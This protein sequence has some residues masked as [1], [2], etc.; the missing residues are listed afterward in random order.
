MSVGTARP[1]EADFTKTL[2]VILLA[3]YLGVTAARGLS[4]AWT[5]AGPIAGYAALGL[6]LSVLASNLATMLI[7]F[8]MRRDRAE[9]RFAMISLTMTAG[10]V[11][12]LVAS[13]LSTRPL[14]H[15][16]ACGITA[17]AMSAT[18]ALSP[19]RFFPPPS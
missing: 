15:A 11:A 2:V 6:F 5:G 1:T 4:L 18:L 3:E 17:V 12:L 19:G 10:Q 13:F 16:V 9:A 8:G 7:A 14:F